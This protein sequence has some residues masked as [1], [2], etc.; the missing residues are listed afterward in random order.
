MKQSISFGFLGIGLMIMIL[1]LA[2]CGTSPPAKFYTLSSMS[3]QK[4]AEKPESLEKYVPVAIGPV[5]IPDYLDR[6]EVV[7]R[8]EQNQLI[9]SEFDLWGGAL[10]S[11]IN[12][13][14]IENISSLLAADGIP[15]VTWKAAMTDAYRVPVVVYRFD[16]SPNGNIILKS[17]WLVIEKEGKNFE[18]FRES[19]FTVPV[20]GD[21]YSTLVS[22]MSDAL[23]ELSKEIAT[24]IKSVIKKK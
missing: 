20:K 24:G 9:I 18:F 22:A 16:A 11:D 15:V 19:D 21:S 6:P 8:A 10:K 23:G 1:S 7:I 5:E 4:S 3:I 2:G 12:R 13:V 17:R 14:L